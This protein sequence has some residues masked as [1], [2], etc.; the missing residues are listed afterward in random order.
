MALAREGVA[1][2]PRSGLLQTSLAQIL[3]TS[4]RTGRRRPPTPIEPCG[5]N[6]FWANDDGA[7]AGC[8]DRSSDVYI[9]RRA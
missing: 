6:Q 9:R 2:N 8:Q 4:P 3:A 1:N 5:P 7:V